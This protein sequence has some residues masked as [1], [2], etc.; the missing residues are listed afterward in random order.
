MI[1]EWKVSHAARIA[2][3]FGAVEYDTR[4]SAHRAIKPPLEENRAIF[5]EYGPE[6]DHRFDPESP[7][8]PVW[9]RKV[10]SR[11]L[12]N[13]RRILALLDVNRRHLTAA[14]SATL[15]Q[16]RQHVDDME[17]RHVGEGQSVG[18]RFPTGMNTI[19]SGDH[20]G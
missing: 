17:V 16:F 13:N 2:A 1:I 4:R 20:D 9:R 8:A 6:G 14:E 7:M 11:I 15:E 12:P 18:I 10:R 19:L 3:T 5:A